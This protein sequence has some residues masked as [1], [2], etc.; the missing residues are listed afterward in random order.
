MYN[1]TTI[2]LIHTIK[3]SLVFLINF[4]LIIVL[5][6]SVI[7]FLKLRATFVHST[8]SRYTFPHLLLFPLNFPTIYLRV[9][10]F[11]QLKLLNCY[12][13]LEYAF[14]S[15]SCTTHLTNCINDPNLIF[16]SENSEFPTQSERVG[17]YNPSY[18]LRGVHPMVTK[19]SHLQ[20]D[21]WEVKVKERKKM[22]WGQEIQRTS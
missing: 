10:L 4:D 13:S 8:V 14:L 1:T 20:S 16:H 18:L 3:Y 19:I 22:W 6:V 11:I 15:K 17:W 21:S 2:L 5:S 12:T 7:F 9:T